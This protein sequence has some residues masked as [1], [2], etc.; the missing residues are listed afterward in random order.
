[1][2]L[3]LPLAALLMAVAPLQDEAGDGKAAAVAPLVGEEVAAIAHFDLVKTDVPAL[4]RRVL[5]NATENEAN[6]EENLQ[7]AIRMVDGT[8]DALRKAG[9]K[10]LYIFLDPSQLP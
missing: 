10:D 2:M 7:N 6:R 5:G 1:M 3:S 4:M 8:V 9:A